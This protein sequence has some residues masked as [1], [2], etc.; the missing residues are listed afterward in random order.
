MRYFKVVAKCGHVGRHRYIV[1]DF[2]IV[3]NDGKEAAFKVRHLPRVKHDR[4]DA[5]LSVEA[6]AKDEYLVGK[7]VQ[8]KDMYFRVHSST[9]QRQC[10]AVDYDL[11]LSET[12]AT[13]YQKCKNPIYYHKLARIIRRD[14]QRRL[15]GEF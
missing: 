5:I 13:K 11:V 4:K 3:A 2:Y 7:A 15:A 14:I 10:G 8:A 1:K 6:I 12:E 9:E